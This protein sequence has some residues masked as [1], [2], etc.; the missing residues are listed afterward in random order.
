MQLVGAHQILGLLRDVALGI[1]RQQL[2]AH[3]GRHDVEQDFADALVLLLRG[4]PLD[5]LAYERLRNRGV[6]AVHRHLV[7]VVGGPA[8][9]QLAQ[10]ARA[11]DDAVLLVGDVHQN[12]RAFAR[13]R[14]FVGRRVIRGIDADIAEMLFAR[15]ADRDFAH[16]DP[17]PP[18]Q[19]EGVA[20][21]AVR[22]AEARHRDAENP[23][24]VEP[25][26]VEGPRHGQQRQRR[27]ETPRNPHD[28]ARAPRVLQAL[29]QTVG[30]DLHDF[31]VELLAP[32]LVLG[33][34]GQLR[35]FAVEP[36]GVERLGDLHFDHR[37]FGA[38]LVDAERRVAL[39]LVFE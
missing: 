35:D 29:G 16:G 27:V 17:Q 28:G 10:V 19:F 5:H 36:F 18:H 38:R 14:I 39:P 4:D 30:L 13:L 34:E 23:R 9:C 26:L 33:Q 15:L 12:L 37:V 32:R 21:G 25:Q 1:R 7:A 2:G 3:G 20:V 24:A 6:D 8:E 22:R 11:D 31:A